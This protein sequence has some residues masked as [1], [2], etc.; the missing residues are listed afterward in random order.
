MTLTLN[1]HIHVLSFI[2][3]PTFRS[4]AAIVSKESIVFT[5]SYRKAFTK[6]DLAIKQVK[7]NLG[8]SFEQT[9]V[10]PSPQCYIP[11]FM[12]IGPLVSEKIFEGFLPCNMGVVA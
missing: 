4:Q 8:L 9:K 2:H 6:F 12:K 1:T 5:F 3:L 7:V 10:D 11:S